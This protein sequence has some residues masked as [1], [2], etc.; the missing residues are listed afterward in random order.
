MSLKKTGTAVLLMMASSLLFAETAKGA[1]EKAA[2]KDNLEQSIAWLKQTVPALETAADR[3]S[4]Y[5]FLGSVLEQSGNY[6][7]ALNAYVQA[8][9]IGAGDAEGMP[10]RSSEQLVIDAV[11]CALSCGD[12]PSA[13]NYLNSQVR[14][15]S[16][17]TVISYVK[18]YEQWIVLC[19][20]E[21]TEDTKEA[22]AILKTYS[23]LDSMKTIRPQLLLTLWHITGDKSYSDNLKKNFPESPEAA[24]V[25]G[26]IQTLPAPF[27]YFVPRTSSASPDTADAAPMAKS[28]IPAVTAPAPASK[29]STEKVMRQQLGLFKDKAN[30]ENLVSKL[31]DKGFAAKITEEVRPS[32]TT[33]YIVAVDETKENNMGDRLR[34]AG[35]ECYPIFE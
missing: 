34:S 18:L 14:N 8:A 4:G 30:A 24:I 27:W 35:F 3:R 12:W 1:A 9:A 6:T 28:E 23:S 15:S 31:K 22:V 13:Q 26:Q 33:Y 7:D 25:K 32:G 19:R 17:Q 10:K 21:K 5:I 16:D 29:K 20:A 11:R 2:A